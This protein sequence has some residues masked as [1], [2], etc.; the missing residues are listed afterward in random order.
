MNGPCD[1][2][3]RWTRPVRQT[4]AGLARLVRYWSTVS[5]LLAAVVLLSPAAS[6]DWLDDVD[7]TRLVEALHGAVP[8][9][10]GVPISQVEAAVSGGVYFP[11]TYPVPTYSQFTSGTDP[12]D[13]PEDIHF[14]DGSGDASLGVSSHS[15]STVGRWFYGNT[16]S[17]AGGANEVTVYEANDW[18]QSILHS[19]GVNRDPEVQDFRVQ[20]F[21][22]IS[23]PATDATYTSQHVNTLKRFDYVINR[24]Q[25]TAVVGLNNGSST[26]IPYLFGHS[27][28]AIAV[29]RTD[30]GHSTGQTAI[31][32][33]GPGRTKP[34]IVAPFSTTSSAT[35]A[36]SSGATMLHDALVD[37]QCGRALRD[38]QHPR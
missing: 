30:G 12:L 4:A 26:A 14:I 28:N 37:A 31:S 38:G 32:S 33:Y 11:D 6:A 10:E 27:Y 36:V 29:G 2:P 21:S 9:G 13:P 8:T 3:M 18:L 16:T 5:A 34:D 7:Y 17:M 22:W 19:T 25:V 23:D 1:H 35:A 15:Q 20:N 24:D